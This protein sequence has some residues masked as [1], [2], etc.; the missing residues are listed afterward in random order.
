MTYLGALFTAK[1][2]PGELKFQKHQIG[3][4]NPEILF[5]LMIS[6]LFLFVEQGGKR[7]HDLGKK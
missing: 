4:N 1:V 3:I 5:S 7:I 2:K 6:V